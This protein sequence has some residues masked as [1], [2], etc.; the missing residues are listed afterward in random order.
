MNAKPNL[1]Q[2]DANLRAPAGTSL[3]FERQKQRILDAATLLLNQKGVWGMTLQAVAG[4]L[5]LTTTSVTYYFKRREHLAVAVFEDSLMRVANLAREAAQEPTPRQR[6]AK[7]MKLYCNQIGDALRGNAR[8]FALLSE[9]RTLEDEARARLVGQYQDVFRTVRGFFG[10]WETEDRK[11][12]LTARTHILSEAL[13]WAEIWLPRYAIGD[14]PNVRHRM[15]SILDGGLATPGTAWTAEPLSYALSPAADEQEAHLRV[16]TRLINEHGYRGASVDKIS[17]ALN[18]KKT[19]FYRHIEGKD[20]LI[21]ECFRN[22]YHRLADLQNLAHQAHASPWQRITTTLSSALALQFR[23]EFPLLISSALQ[24]MPAAVRPRAFERANRTALGFMGVL[25]DGMQEGT[26]RIID[27]LIASQ[28]ML[29]AIN[30]SYDLRGWRE[31]LP[32]D[33]AIGVYSSVL[34]NGI[35]DPE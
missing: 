3:R 11:L 14:F 21:T 35:F 13:S 4:A 19:S 18:R 25:L 20:D 1:A 27:P 9:I 22:S 33:K 16:A 24:A 7:Y 29:S 32:V 5:D 10:A 23:D 2:D 12:L 30:S 34:A 6:V 15:M 26:V 31:R 17:R 28:I 8:P